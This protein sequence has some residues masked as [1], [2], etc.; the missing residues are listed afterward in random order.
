[1]KL[2]NINYKKPKL[3]ILGAGTVGEFAT[4]SA[5]G[6]GASV[7]VFDKSLSKLRRMQDKI[8]ARVDMNTIN[9]KALEKTLQYLGFS[10]WVQS[11]PSKELLEQS[12]RDFLKPSTRDISLFYFFTT[13]H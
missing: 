1:M 8:S 12:L 13:L 4:R 9:T 3:V 7:K 2:D 5:I 6:L 11:N 10:V